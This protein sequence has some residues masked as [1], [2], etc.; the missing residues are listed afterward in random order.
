MS[1]TCARN[2]IKLSIKKIRRK[3]ITVKIVTIINT[4]V[5]YTVFASAIGENMAKFI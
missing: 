4:S 5:N 1:F 2:S 3:V